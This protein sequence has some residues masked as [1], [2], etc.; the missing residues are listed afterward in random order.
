MQARAILEAAAELLKEGV[1]VLPEIMVPLIGHVKELQH[2]K[3][4]ILEEAEV[5]KKQVRSR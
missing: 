5:V 2:Q 3:K 1:N 4:I